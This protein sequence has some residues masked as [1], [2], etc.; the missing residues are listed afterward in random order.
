MLKIKQSGK[1][2]AFLDGLASSLDLNIHSDLIGYPH[3]S[4]TSALRKDMVRIGDDM[5]KV[6]DSEYEKYK[7]EERAS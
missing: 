2:L 7:E 6:V 5:R 1:F 3:A 4:T